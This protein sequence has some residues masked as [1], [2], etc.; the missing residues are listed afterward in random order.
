MLLIIFSLI[1]ACGDSE[2]NDDISLAL[3]AESSATRAYIAPP[4]L[5]E[6]IKKRG[7]LIVITT[8]TPTTY[9]FDRDN[10]PTGPEYDM[11]QAYAKA[12]QIDVEYIILQQKY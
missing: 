2:N 12:L 7:K 1:A 5:L 9:Y 11:T 3:P 10:Q 8:N 4:S 6:K